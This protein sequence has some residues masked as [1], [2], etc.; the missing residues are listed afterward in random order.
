MRILENILIGKAQFN[1]FDDLKL[2]KL[3]ETCLNVKK[4]PS[5]SREIGKM[6]KFK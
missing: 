6:T 2:R 1:Q 3:V 5:N 4:R